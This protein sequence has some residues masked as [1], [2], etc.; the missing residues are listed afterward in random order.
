M[1][2]TVRPTTLPGTAQIIA[3]FHSAT[4]EHLEMLGVDP[5]R[6]TEATICRSGDGAAVRL[7]YARIPVDEICMPACGITL[8]SS[9]YLQR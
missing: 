8:R 9:R 7:R 6:R 4:P 1:T 5:T 2:L 3:Y